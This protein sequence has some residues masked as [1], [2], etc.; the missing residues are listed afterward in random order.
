MTHSPKRILSSKR[1][2]ISAALLSTSHSKVHQEID[3]HRFKPSLGRMV[4][5]I[6]ERRKAVVVSLKQGPFP[7][8]V[9]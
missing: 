4:H 8:S 3:P 1:L 2:Q 9:P 7:L 6:Y 5:A